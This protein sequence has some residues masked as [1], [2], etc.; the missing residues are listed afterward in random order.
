MWVARK[1][2]KMSRKLTEDQVAIVDAA[3]A[4]AADEPAKTILEI[5]EAKIIE[6]DP[7]AHAER[8]KKAKRK[9]GVWDTTTKPGDAVDEETGETGVCTIFARV[10]EGETT[11]LD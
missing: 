4:A 2:A 5:A 7:D 10:D 1:V 3:C 11:S 6:A 9:K 8:I